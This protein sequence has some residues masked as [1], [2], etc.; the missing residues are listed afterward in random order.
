MS[1]TPRYGE[2]PLLDD[3]LASLLPD[4]VR[5]LGE[6]V[7][8]A[9]VYDLAQGLIG[10]GSDGRNSRTPSSCSRRRTAPV[11]ERPEAPR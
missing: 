3:E 11:I 7:T 4:V 5:I 8:R 1:L 2:T 10:I 9:A 6:P